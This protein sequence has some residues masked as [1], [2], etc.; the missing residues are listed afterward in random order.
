MSN[1]VLSKQWKW[2]PSCTAWGKTGLNKLRSGEKLIQETHWTSKNV[3]FSS[4][5]KNEEEF[6]TFFAEKRVEEISRSQRC[7]H[8]QGPPKS[9]SHSLP[10]K[11]K[12]LKLS[13]SRF[14]FY[15]VLK[16][17]FWFFSLLSSNATKKP[18]QWNLANQQNEVDDVKACDRLAVV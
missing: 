17:K 16:W 11:T 7:R 1:C 8:S 6:S 18:H 13:L 2:M 15:V 5:T 3:I 10:S 9:H 4:R 14:V 12:S